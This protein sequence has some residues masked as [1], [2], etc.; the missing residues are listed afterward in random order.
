MTKIIEMKSKI[1][2]Y[3]AVMLWLL[4]IS[5]N[6][7]QAADV[8]LVKITQATT[9][10]QKKYSV[11]AVSVLVVSQDEVLV[12][13]HS[14]IRDWGSNKPFTEQDMYRIG[15]ISKSFAGVLA[16]RLQQKG[17]INLNDSIVDYGLASYMNNSYPARVITLAQLLEHTAGLSDLAKAEWDYNDAE[18]IT[19]KQ[20]FDLKL[21]DHKTRWEPGVHRSYSNVGAGLFGLALELKLGQSY[22]TLM[23]E[24][25]FKPLQM[26]DSDMLLSDTT[27]KRLIKGYDRDGRKPIK[28]WHNIYRPFAAINS[29]NQDMVLW[30]QMLLNTNNDFLSTT[31]RKRLVHPQTTLAGQ[32]GLEYGYGLGVYQ[33]QTGGHSFYGHGGDADGYLT[34][35][36]L[37]PESG[38]AYFVMINAFNKRPLNEIVNL[39]ESQI[40]VDLPKPKYPL[41]LELTDKEIETYQG[42]YLQV[43][44]RFGILKPVSTKRL[45][46]RYQNGQLMYQ[47]NQGREVVIHKVRKDQ[48]RTSNQSVATMAFNT[49]KDQFYFQGELGNFVKV[50]Q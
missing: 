32:D 1:K 12:N 2:I 38:L 6:I 19:L 15:S 44:S 37:N 13:L 17:L 45:T 33:W 24:H 27:V 39:I 31:D 30:L 25:V 28:Y 26:N 49:H 29:D 42:E 18:P 3:G 14:G 8:D 21:G 4:I 5:I 16:L 48:F 50:V 41:R 35:F 46:V 22:E 7:S 9:E 10:I 40:T 43:T 34:R 20:A 11:A 36:G 23:Q 47:F